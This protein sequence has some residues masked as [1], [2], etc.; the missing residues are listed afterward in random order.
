MQNMSIATWYKKTVGSDTVNTVAD[1]TEIVPSSLYRQLPE[2]LSPENVVKIAR[3]YGVSAINGLVA[4]GLLD[5]SDISQLQ[6]SDALINASNDE[7]LQELARRLKENADADW[8]NDR[9]RLCTLCHELVHAK[10]RDLGCGTRFGAIPSMSWNASTMWT[11]ASRRCMNCMRLRPRPIPH[12][13][14]SSGM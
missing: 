6:V 4:L 1:N 12:Q 13:M 14:P 11:A 2:K 3:A 10:Y 5:D 9:Q 7:L 8:L